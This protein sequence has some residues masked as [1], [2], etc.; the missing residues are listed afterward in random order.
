MSIVIALIGPVW[1][2]TF[3]LTPGGSDGW[4]VE[5]RKLVPWYSGLPS[6]PSPFFI[7]TP[8]ET[9]IYLVIVDDRGEGGQLDPGEGEG[10]TGTG[11]G[12]R[13][14]QKEL[15]CLIIIIARDIVAI[16]DGV[17]T[18]G[19]RRACCSPCCLLPS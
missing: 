9:D 2:P 18:C 10:E 15:L 7:G 5:G 11:T 14:C 19:R 8:F 3:N 12:R 17:E 13:Q 16:V 4:V 1:T 6:V